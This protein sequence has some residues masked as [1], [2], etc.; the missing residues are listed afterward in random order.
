MP[1]RQGICVIII[2]D[3]PADA[4]LM[5]DAL[6]R[7]AESMPEFAMQVRFDVE[8]AASIENGIQMLKAHM[9]DIALLDLSVP[10]HSG[11][12]GITALKDAYP[13]LPLI[14]VSGN[15]SDILAIEAVK[16][17]ADDFVLKN[18]VSPKRLIRAVRYTIERAKKLPGGTTD[19]NNL[20]RLADIVKRLP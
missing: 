16:A 12:E 7:A 10:P 15:E 3:N 19:T 14:V 2:D 13:W 9:C 20:Q 17:G 4:R 6:E 5:R 11:T 18:E 1:H 8:E